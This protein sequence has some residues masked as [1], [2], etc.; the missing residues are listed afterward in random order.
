MSRKDKQINFVVSRL[1]EE[2]IRQRMDEAGIRNMSA[3]LRKM[4]LN[5]YIIQLD[6]SQIGEMISL[7][8]RCSNNLNQLAKR[9]N[10]NKNIYADDI[11]DIQMQLD[12]LWNAANKILASLAGIPV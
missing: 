2:R 6:M 9:A 12:D 5:G 10:A 1:E 7:L 8:R 3:Y 11:Q 4:A